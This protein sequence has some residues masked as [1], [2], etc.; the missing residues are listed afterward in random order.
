[1]HRAGAVV[2]VGQHQHGDLLVQR[3]RDLFGLHQHQ[4]VTAF[5]AQRFGDVEIGGEVAAFAHDALAHGVVGSSQVQ[6]GRQNLEQVDRG[7][8]GGHHGARF[9]ADQAR[10]L[11]TH[12][13]RH[14]EPA[15]LV[16]ALDQVGAPLAGH[17]VGHAGRGRGGHHAERIAIEVDRAGGDVEELAQIA[18]RVLRVEGGAVLL[19]GH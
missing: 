19:C 17:D 7:A 1:M 4:L 14:G 2:H 11:V 8:V 3:A 5:L 10:D 6:R 16:P 18:Q 9:G 12:L 15:V 13:L